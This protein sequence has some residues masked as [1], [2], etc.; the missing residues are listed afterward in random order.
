[1]SRHIITLSLYAKAIV[2]LRGMG[3][4]TFQENAATGI[5]V[6]MAVGFHSLPLFSAMFAGLWVS[7]WVGKRVCS[8]TQ[9]VTR[10]LYG[11]NGALVGLA[12]YTLFQSIPFFWMTLSI[13]VA[14]AICSV[15]QSRW[16]SSLPI[17]TVPF[18]LVTL[19]FTLLFTLVEGSFN[20][21]FGKLE[22]LTSLHNATQRTI[23]VLDGLK[24][25]LSGVGQIMFVQPLLPSVLI[26][27]G[28]ACSSRSTALWACVGSACGM[29]VAVTINLPN[30]LSLQGLCGFSASLT[31]IALSQR[32]D[33]PQS[34]ALSRSNL[35]AKGRI[36]AGVIFATLLSVFSDWLGVVTLTLPFVLSCWIMILKRTSP[37][38]PPP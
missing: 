4:V 26:L 7:T 9:D 18:L 30:S 1:M 25:V 27:I 10:G 31:A 33:L 13:F 22:P 3:Q 24:G 17:F 8:N 23:T 19:L 35:L 15:I 28:I 2:L 16:R 37:S 34:R 38:T 32:Y 12:F 6:A 21:P 11:Y 20:L 14:S 5:F 29:M 36:M